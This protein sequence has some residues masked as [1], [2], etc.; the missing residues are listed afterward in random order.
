[1]GLVNLFWVAR[2]LLE[3]RSVQL[4]EDEQ[5][6]RQFSFPLLNPADVARLCRMG[7]WDHI[8]AGTC[9][10]EHDRMLARL[11]VIVSGKADVR[12]DGEKVAELGD[13]QFVGQIA[14]NHWREGPRQHLS[15]RVDAH[16]LVVTRQARDVFQRQPDVELQLGPSLGAD[17]TRLLKSA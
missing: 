6:L 17:L 15:Q 11:S 13:G 12:L 7:T 9:P 1:M 16:H 4:T 3:R 8:E 14:Y 2:L 10:V 5:P